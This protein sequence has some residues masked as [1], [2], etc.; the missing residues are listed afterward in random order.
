MGVLQQKSVSE[1]SGPYRVLV[2]DDSPSNFKI[3]TREDLEV[4]EILAG[5]AEEGTR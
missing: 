5:R 3:T 4:A 2:V 1:A